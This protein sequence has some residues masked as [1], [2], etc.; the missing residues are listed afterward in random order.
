LHVQKVGGIGGS[1]RHLLTLLPALA[2][3]EV[4]VR[5]CV[6]ATGRAGGFT[7]SLREL[8]VA[9]AVVPAGRDVSATLVTALWREIRAF[10]P[11]LVHTHL[12]HA[13]LHGQ[14]AAQ[15]A[16]VTGISSVH[17]THAFYEREPYRTAARLAGHRAKRTIAISAHVRGFIESVG[18]PRRGTVRMIHYGIDSSRWPISAGDRDRARAELGLDRESVAVGV[19]SRLVPHKGHSL[20]LDAYGTASRE[21][22]ELRLLIAG[23]GPLRPELERKAR[24]LG[25]TVRFVG[26]VKEIRRFMGACDVLAFP[27][28]PAF[29]E[30][31]GLAALEG[32]AAGRPIVATATCSLPEVVSSGE[33]GLLVDPGSADELA[34]ALVTL[35]ADPELR[36]KMGQAAN[37]RARETFS[38]EAMVDRTIAVYDEAC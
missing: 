22:P 24:P 14:L 19:A 5:M 15:L 20:L 6:A 7:E 21:R 30:G 12:I 38:L 33:S 9:H 3:S 34:A 23:E 31:F 27:S 10:R 35:A 29:G 16:G 2:E 17:G 8:G 26:F 11:D 18:I 32:M 4:D 1:E 25:E 28:Q 36:A 13:D 37:R